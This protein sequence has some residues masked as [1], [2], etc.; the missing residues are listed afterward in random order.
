MSE[1]SYIIRDPFL[2]HREGVLRSRGEKAREGNIEVAKT[3]AEF[4]RS[5]LGPMGM[6]KLMINKFGDT[7]V[8]RDGAVILDMMDI[9]HPIAKFLKEAAKSVESTVG[10]GTKTTIILVGELVKRAE[11]LLQS[12]I[13]PGVIVSGYKK[14]CEIALG[15]LKRLSKP[16]SI[17]D[18]ELMRRIIKNMIGTRGIEGAIDHLTNLIIKAINVVIEFRNGKAIIDRGLVHIIKK[19]GKD[20]L[21]SELIKGVVI[22]KRL[23][24][25]MMPKKVVNARIAVL[26]MALKVDPFKHL[27]PYKREIHI[28]GNELVKRFI[29]EEDEIEKDFVRLI[30]STGAN[31][32]VCRK[33]IGR[34]A[35]H[36]FAKAGVM[37]VERLLKD[38]RIEPV[39]RATGAMRVANLQDLREGDLG[40]ADLVEERKF[41]KDR[42]VVIEGGK[43]SKVATILLRGDPHQADEAERAIK[44]AVAMISNLVNEPAYV[45]GGGAVEEALSIAVRNESLKYPGK[46][47]IAMQAFANSLEVIPIL[48]ARNSGLDPTDIITEL[49]AKHVGGMYEYGIDVFSKDIVNVIEAGL[50]EPLVV[51]EQVLKTCT[52][53]ASTII[54]IDDVIDRRYAKRH[55]GEMP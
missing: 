54:R 24:H 37:A 39:V 15:H 14:A 25:P 40:H 32:V 26:D 7:A 6:S 17:N 44:D 16:F 47:Q 43:A 45:P 21:E 5:S 27:Q 55:R 35:K 48:L 38:E 2:L 18:P 19:P 51:K 50:I 31:V 8:T 1:R 34:V 3:M 53:V 4:L 12:R 30:V 9:Y 46:E 33:R 11:R 36:E 42:M 22:D 13:Q 52:E 28:S 49:R 29:D 23:A 10:D 20:I 41:G